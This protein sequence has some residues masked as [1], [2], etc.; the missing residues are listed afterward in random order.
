MSRPLYDKIKE[1]CALTRARF[2]MPGHGGEGDGDGLYASSRFDWTEVKGLDNLL[3]SSDVILS[4]EKLIAKDFGYE[5]ALML[6][7]GATSAMHIALNVARERG[8]VVL[9]IGAMHKSFWS[10][11]TLYGVKACVSDGNDDE[12]FSKEKISA[13]FTTSPD[14][15]GK[16]RDIESLCVKAHEAGALFVVDEAH[17]AHFPYSQLLPDNAA[18][19]ADMSIVGMHKTLPVYGGGALLCVNGS[20][21]YEKCVRYRSL[22]HSTSPDYLVMASMDYAADYMR[23]N[24]EKEYAR[25]KNV[26]DGFANSLKNGVVIDN[27][28]FTRVVIE[29]KGKDCHALCDELAARGFFA[30]AAYGD[31][32]VLIVTPFNADKLELLS[33]ELNNIQL[34]E[35][36]GLVLPEPVHTSVADGE[37]E[38]V[39]VD[40]ASGRISAGEIGIYPPGVPVIRRGDLIDGEIVAFIKKYTNRLFG[41]ASGRVAVIK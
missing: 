4:S 22:I 15:F 8:S 16:V 6:T 10:A 1:Y 41:L 20:E 21:L 25:I 19:Y 18:A 14:Y 37:C 7:C 27:D 33:H 2:C 17:S 29:F 11:C 26:I 23:T 40:E 35:S 38:F 31:R 34:K 28:D 32:L 24:G 13:V 30:E 12:I 36:Q 9:A 3:E 39:D 5:H